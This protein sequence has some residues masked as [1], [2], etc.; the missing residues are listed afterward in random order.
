MGAWHHPEHYSDAAKAYAVETRRREISL[1][2]DMALAS[3]REAAREAGYALTVHGSLSRDL[4]LVAIPWIDE[5]VE[6]AELV[7]RISEATKAATGWGFVSGEGRLEG[8]PHGRLAVTIVAS[9]EIHLD[10]SIMPRL[11]A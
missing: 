10:L 1:F 9:A 2:L 3:L 7:S 8:K 5:A 11:P 4:D 6:P